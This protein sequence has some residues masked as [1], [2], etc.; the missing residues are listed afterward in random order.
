MSHT[1]R[2]QTFRNGKLCT[3]QGERIRVEIKLSEIRCGD[4]V[5]GAV[6][7]YIEKLKSAADQFYMETAGMGL[8]GTLYV[9]KSTKHYIESARVEIDPTPAPKPARTPASTSETPAAADPMDVV[10]RIPVS[11]W[12]VDPP[13]AA[14]GGVGSAPEPD[15][16]PITTSWTAPSSDPMQETARREQALQQALKLLED[17]KEGHLTYREDVV[18]RIEE[19]A[20][21]ELVHSIVTKVNR[22]HVTQTADSEIRWKA[23]SRIPDALPTRQPLELLGTVV[24]L[25]KEGKGVVRIKVDAVVSDQHAAAIHALRRR[26]TGPVSLPYTTDAV[27]RRLSLFDSTPHQLRFKGSA[28]KGLTLG[29]RFEFSIDSVELAN[30]DED[31]L[32]DIEQLWHEELH[33]K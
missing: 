2:L 3:E 27:R 20:W 26:G 18:A 10:G 19:S 17:F 33:R 11:S 29:D 5:N 23:V 4:G 31:V 24:A 6:E 13:A 28:A 12:R 30:S 14:A 9:D 7:D 1:K 8:I 25:K 15:Q 16:T 21:P 22:K 32:R